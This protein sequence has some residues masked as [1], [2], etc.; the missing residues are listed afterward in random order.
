[1]ARPVLK[2][3]INAIDVVSRIV[4]S[5]KNIKEITFAAYYYVLQS[6]SD[7]GRLKLYRLRNPSPERIIRF[8]GA[9]RQRLQRGWQLG[10]TSRVKLKSGEIRHVPQIDFAC[11]C[12][13]SNAER[14]TKCLSHFVKAKAG[15]LLRSGR[16]YHYYGPVLLSERGWEVFIGN[17]LLCN[18]VG[19]KPVVDTRWFAYSMRRGFSNL[20]II[21][22]TEKPGPKV[23]TKI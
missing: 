5:N 10:F 7:K 19:K 8:V 13:V 23:I 18:Q 20:R 3:S 9:L 1:M 11:P 21:A 16:S 15:Y 6:L 17:A 14:V 2:K 4:A 12:S 22:S